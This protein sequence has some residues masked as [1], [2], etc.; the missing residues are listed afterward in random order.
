[1]KRVYFSA[2]A[3]RSNR[4]IEFEGEALCMLIVFYLWII[5]CILA[6]NKNTQ[7]VVCKLSAGATAAFLGAA[8]DIITK[9]VSVLECRAGAG[10]VHCS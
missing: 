2:T 3:N 6:G 8:C 7:L 4:P 9:R 1:M 5:P 10:G